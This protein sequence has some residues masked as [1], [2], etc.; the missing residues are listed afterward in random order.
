MKEKNIIV[1]MTS[2]EGGGVE[3]NFFIITNFLSK[4]FDKSVINL[5]NNLDEIL[6]KN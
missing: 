3:K 1:F 4:K 2:R 6:I 5:S